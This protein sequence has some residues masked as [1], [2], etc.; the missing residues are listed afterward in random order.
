MNVTLELAAREYEDNPP[1]VYAR[2]GYNLFLKLRDQKEHELRFLDNPDVDCT[3]NVSERLARSFK[4]GLR[5]QGTFRE[6]P[7][8]REH[9][10]SMR[11]RCDSL[12][13]IE[14]TR[15]QGGNVWQRAREVF[16]RPKV[17]KTVV[18]VQQAE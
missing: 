3:N 2:K 17:K 4:T 10:R 5:A 9:N 14:T 8:S 16:K 6:G 1:P 13:D 18:A 11:Y 12:S 7:N 15:M